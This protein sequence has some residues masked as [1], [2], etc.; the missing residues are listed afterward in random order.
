MSDT[1][2][3]RESPGEAPP[4]E[5]GPEGST[6][7]EDGDE[8]YSGLLGAFRYGFGRSESTLFRL[9][10]L[11]SFLLGAALALVFALGLLSWFLAT[12]GQSALV[13]TA[14]AF[15]GV[16]ALF[17]LGPLFAPV[18]FVARRHRRGEST[19]GY[20]AAHALTGVAFVVLLY[21]GIA[22]SVP[23]QF[24]SADPGAVGA[25]LY[26][27]PPLWGLAPPVVGAAL[28]VVVHRLLG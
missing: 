26:S 22:I 11:F 28:V 2:A 25:F 10:A 6:S 23:P 1:A 27:L 17:V 21:A 3:T 13:T 5:P 20:D 8:G 16:V 14:N 19:P 15:L 18:L 24:Q 7:D 9:Y 4:D 12:V